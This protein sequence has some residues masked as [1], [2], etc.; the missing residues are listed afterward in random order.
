MVLIKRDRGPQKGSHPSTTEQQIHPIHWDFLGMEH[1]IHIFST[2]ERE[3]FKKSEVRYLDVNDRIA[4]AQGKLTRTGEIQELKAWGVT[5]FWNKS[6]KRISYV[7]MLNR[8]KK[9]SPD[10]V[11]KL[12]LDPIISMRHKDDLPHSES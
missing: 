8:A 9:R 6:K 10:I 3:L 11:E 7:E 1:A 12:E 4:Y 2:R 5:I